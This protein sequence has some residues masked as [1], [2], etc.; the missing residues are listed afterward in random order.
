MLSSRL[1]WKVFATYAALTLVSATVF[2]AILSSRQKDIVVERS[3]QR[4]HDSAVLLRNDMADVF[5]DGPGTP[6]QSTLR[7]LGEQTG[8]R[9]TLVAEDGTVLGD[10]VED[11]AA[12]EN[13]RNRDELLQ[14]RTNEFGVSQRPSPTLG[15]PMMYVALRVGEGKRPAG[16]VR[17]AMPMESVHSQVTSVQRLILVTALLASLAALTFTYFIVGRIIRPLATLTQAAK[18][19]A[20]GDIQQEVDVPGRDEL[21]TLAE[22]FNSMSHQL[23]TRIHELDRKGRE[24]VENSERLEAVLG[25]MIE[26]VLAVDGEERILFANLAARSLLEIAIPDV[27]G[28]PIWEAVRNPAIQEVVRKALE[29]TTQESVELELARTQSIVK[30]SA[31]RLAGDPCPGVILVFHDVTKLRRLQNMR[32]QFVSNVSHELKTPLTSI[33]AH[34]ETLLGGAIDD[35]EHNRK[36]LGRIAEQ[37]DRL[38]SLILDLLRLGKVE[39]GAGVFDVTA[40]DVAE[41]VMSCIEERAEVAEAKRIELT[42]ES[43][44]SAISVLADAEGLQTILDNLIEN[45]IKYTPEGGRVEIR[46]RADESMVLL[47]VVDNGAGIAKEH[48]SRIF[49][50]FYRADKARSRELGGTGLGLSI[51]KHFVQEFGGG[52]E[53]SSEP[54]KG[55]TFSVRL[56]LAD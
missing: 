51:V 41:T 25:G 54:G 6:L 52:V 47:E 2:V 5:E 9:M 20:D 32:Q 50:R 17:V 18:S 34:A 37:A 56:P 22:S 36:F 29:T 38:H 13:H 11:P 12:M 1:F 55:A 3:Q 31:T 28:H 45:A 33:Q 53:V 42:T 43:P 35:P 46:W 23:S 14:A 40:V 26:G 15:I 44:N 48:Q 7:R 49:E 21:G 30:L 16:F 24:S 8:T 4:L 27:V 19:I 10:S 39:S